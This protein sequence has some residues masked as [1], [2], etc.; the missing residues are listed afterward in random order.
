MGPPLG[1]WLGTN[2][3]PASSQEVIDL[4]DLT[5]DDDKASVLNMS[6]HRDKTPLGHTPVS[7]LSFSMGRDTVVH[8]PKDLTN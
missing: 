2:P 6:S 1:T 5:M 3:A 4:I 8:N 7:T